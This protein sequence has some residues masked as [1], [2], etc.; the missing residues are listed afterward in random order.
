MMDRLTEAQYIVQG[1][2]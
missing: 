2:P 1:V